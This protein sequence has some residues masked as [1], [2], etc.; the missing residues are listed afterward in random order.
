VFARGSAG[1]ISHNFYNLYKSVSRGGTPRE[2]AGEDVRVAV[3]PREG[4]NL[5]TVRPARGRE[6]VFGS[7]GCDQL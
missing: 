6:M 5:L 7:T 4:R 3:S 1:D 2:F